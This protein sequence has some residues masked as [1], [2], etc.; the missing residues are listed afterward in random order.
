MSSQDNK[1]LE[2]YTKINARLTEA[3]DLLTL[4][5][6]EREKIIKL[7]EGGITPE[8][9]ELMETS[10]KSFETLSKYV[11]SLKKQAEELKK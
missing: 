7:A 3:L 6:E 10:L 1:T 4:L 8:I 2:E 9:Q 5:N 11:D